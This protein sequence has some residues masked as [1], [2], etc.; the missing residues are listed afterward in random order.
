[1][2][3][4]D[5]ITD[6][7]RTHDIQTILG[8]RKRSIVCPLPQ[9]IHSSNTPSFSVFWKDGIQYFKC[10]GS[11]DC[12]G[13]VIDLVGYLNVPG[14]D[15][16][17][18]GMVRKALAHIDSKY[19]ISIPIPVKTVKLTGSEWFDMLPISP[20][21][22]AYAHGRGLTDETIERFKLGSRGGFLS[23]PAFREG[24][25]TGIKLRNILP[26]KFRF[27]SLKGSIQSLF[28]FDKVAYVTDQAVF[29]VKGEIPCM[30][31]DQHGFL[32]CAPTAGEGSWDEHWR[33]ALAFSKNIVIGD[34]DGPGRELGEKRALLLGADLVFPPPAFKDI[35]EFLLADPQGFDILMEKWRSDEH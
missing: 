2:S 18:K 5:D 20:E 30:L 13:D 34:N 1:M 29:I 9:H 33:A 28:N 24:R 6:A 32:A 26:E 23:M 10:H 4:K 31:L 17:S 27:Y 15:R 22:R 12:T 11:C 25:L 35:D 3:L 21:A 14:Y 16:K 7:Q 8:T 19:E